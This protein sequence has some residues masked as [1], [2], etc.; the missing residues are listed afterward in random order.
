MKKMK[1]LIYGAGPFGSF[2]G[3]R[4][5][6][7]GHE[8]YLLARGQRLEDLKKYGVVIENSSTGEQTLTEV[9]MVES[10]SEEDYY[11]L[12]IIP[13]RKN[14][15]VDILPT[16]AA[17]KKVPTFLFMMNNAEGQERLVQALGRERVMIGFPLPGGERRG[18]IIRMLPADEKKKWTLP[19]GEVDGSVTMRTRQ[20]ATVL[21]SMKGY[22]VQIRRDMDAWLKTH[23][24]LIM[25]VLVPAL[26]GTGTDLERMARTR[27]ALVMASL[28]LKEALRSLRRAGVKPTPVVT[29]VI[30]LIPEPLMVFLLRRL[31]REEEM[32]VSGVG[33]ALAARDEMKHLTDEFFELIRPVGGATPILDE[34]YLYYDPATP[35][36]PD[37]SSEIPLNWRGFWGFLLVLAAMVALIILLV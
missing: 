25:P 14:L 24:A 32:E 18:H 4:L 7:A 12:V 3:E 8:V 29:R 15:V 13:M 36:L 10:L 11:D 28:G 35:I 26:Y 31:T 23:A 34:L 5:T 21:G 27:D 22:K 2:F 20:V 19:V 30:E 9:P 6:D 37:G 16:L 17:N 33:H 1:I